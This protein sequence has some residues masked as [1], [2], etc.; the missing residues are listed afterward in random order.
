MSF[1]GS[2]QMKKEFHLPL[3]AGTTCGEEMLRRSFNKKQIFGAKADK[4][5]PVTP[6]VPTQYALVNSM[7]STNGSNADATSPTK[8]DGPDLVGRVLRFYGYTMETVQESNLEKDRLRKVTLC[9]FLEDGT[10]SVSEPKMD[11]SGFAFMG[12]LLKRHAIPDAEGRTITFDGL[13]VGSPVSFYGR[14]FVLT[15]ADKFTRDFYASVGVTLSPVVELPNDAYTTLRS[16]PAGF[17]VHDVPSIAST[18][19]LNITLSRDQINATKQFLAKDRQVLRCQCIWDEQKNLYGENHNLTLY[20]FL[21]DDTIAVAEKDTPNCGRDPFPNFVRRQRIPRPADTTTGKFENHNSSLTFQGKDKSCAQFYTSEDIR[22]GNILFVFGRAVRICSYDEF[23]REFLA[24]TYGITAY[25]P[26]DTSIPPKPKV[27]REPPPYNG[28]GDE[29]DSLGSCQ[30]L[31]IK[32]PRKDGSRFAKHGNNVVKFAMKLENGVAA[33]EIRRFVLSCFLADDTICIFEPVQRNSGI[34]G[35]KF[36]QRQKVTNAKTGKPFVSS[37]FHVGLHVSINAFPFICT[38]TDERSLNYMEGN[39]GTYV[40]SNIGSVIQKLKA[41]LLSGSSGL[42]EAMFQL[43]RT[44][45]PV[46][47]SHLATVAHQLRLDLSEQEILTILRFFARQ[48]ETY[49]TY[50]ELIARVLPEGSVVGRD[51]SSWEALFQKMTNADLQSFNIT[52]VNAQEEKA[53]VDNAAA[54]CASQFLTLYAQR[55]ALFNQEFKF[56]V[57]YASDSKIGEREFNLAAFDRLHLPLDRAD[58]SA[59]C[60][61]LFPPTAARITYEDLHRLFNGTSNQ[62]FNMIQI[63]NGVAK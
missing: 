31:D 18:S 25:N 57:D 34:V 32:P 59:L 19:A 22:V 37:D 62:S 8:E 4:T 29:L 28:F 11:N 12:T 6:A 63:K 10:I 3:V 45:I 52:S 50:E 58:C 16:R 15:D 41:M 43:D 60:K 33:D 47:V 27:V 49:A 26:I 14:Q 5:G 36:L 56:S 55:P 48:G 20:Y 1:N 21:S 39:A 2:E 61:K 13:A 51:V 35:G 46:D 44:T 54:R 17:K 42:A 40:H 24:T 23:T 7:L 38:A 53:R 30:R 9:Y